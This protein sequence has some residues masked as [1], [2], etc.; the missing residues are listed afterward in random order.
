[1]DELEKYYE[2]LKG[3]KADVPDTYQSFKNTLSDENSA[4]QYY[5]YLRD[6]KFDTP[7]NYDSFSNTFE[8]KK[9]DIT[10]L[11]S[12]PLDGTLQLPAQNDYSFQK[13]LDSQGIKPSIPKEDKPVGLRGLSDM[14]ITERASRKK[15]AGFLPQ[16]SDYAVQDNTT[17]VAPRKSGEQIDFIQHNEEKKQAHSEHVEEGIKNTAQKYLE[18]QGVIVTDEDKKGTPGKSFAQSKPFGE[19]EIVSK[20]SALFNQTVEKY[21]E[22]YQN[23]DATF[24]I[25]KDGTLGLKR[26]IGGMEGLSKGWNEATQ[27]DSDAQDFVHNMDDYDRVQ[28]MEQQPANKHPEY[29]GDR[30]NTMGSIAEFGA[31]QAPFLGKA[32]AGAI[33]GTA[34]SALGPETGFTSLAALPKVLSFLATAH[35]MS[36]HGAM[37]ETQRRYSILRNDNPNGDKI[38]QMK[39]ATEGG[40]VGSIAGIA[41][42]ALL[43]GE[44]GAAATNILKDAV[45]SE[46]KSVIK[47]ALKNVYK[48]SVHMGNV[49]AGIEGAK[50]LVGAVQGVHTVPSDIAKDMAGAW[51]DN[52]KT[53]AILSGVMAGVGMVP[54]VVKSA[55]KYALKDVNPKAIETTLKFNEENGKIPEGSSVEVM[56]E[57]GKYNEALAQTPKGLSPEAQASMAGL[58]E[59]QNSLIEEQKTKHSSAKADYDIQVNALEEQINKIKETGK[60]FSAEIDEMSGE[61]YTQRN[62]VEVTPPQSL[63][64]PITIGNKDGTTT[65]EPLKEI[66]QN[67]NDKIKKLE[68][69][70]D[71][72]LA[73]VSKPNLKLNLVSS[74][75]LVN[76]KDPVGNKEI[77]DNIKEKYKKLKQLIECL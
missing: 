49:G 54:K 38:E 30:G 39:K 64:E 7:D 66:Q 57:L 33:V 73:K 28:F 53:G 58:I 25:G 6:N 71:K 2:Y 34:L 18:S 26:T 69:E 75:D 62:G 72:E 13:V 65:N 56:N 19:K 15:Q 1:M 46:G 4:K 9:K 35:D 59:K 31:S 60:P 36:N 16:V 10:T 20:N 8:L 47:E 42:N 74:K 48:S 50:Q 22:A 21:R 17:N 11:P 55:F 63:P 76:S 61:K 12:K 67:S 45:S 51:V 70:R 68:E 24:A 27:G 29:L 40:M 5:Q 23:G 41:T 44:G 37:A 77:H 14:S 52:A 32:A 3:A 43:M